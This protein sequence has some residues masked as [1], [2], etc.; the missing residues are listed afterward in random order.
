MRYSAPGF[1]PAVATVFLLSF[2]LCL[3]AAAAG[4][5]APKATAT[6]PAKEL[7]G[8]S[9]LPN[10]APPATRTQTTGSVDQNPQT[11]QMN[12]E[13]KQKVEKEGK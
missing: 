1:V 6:P 4:D 8:Q 9:S 13:E 7:P 5:A 2:T 10:A 11:K 3:N 12:E